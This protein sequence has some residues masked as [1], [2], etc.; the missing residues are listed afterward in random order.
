M[1][2]SDNGE[3]LEVQGLHLLSQHK[4]DKVR[5]SISFKDDILWF[6]VAIDDLLLM[7]KLNQVA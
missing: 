7:K 6:E 1:R 3:S 2:R 4:G 5:I